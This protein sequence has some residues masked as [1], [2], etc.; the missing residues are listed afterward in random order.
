MKAVFIS[1]FVIIFVL[2]IGI[3]FSPAFNEVNRCIDQE[4]TFTLQSTEKLKEIQ[5]QRKRREGFCED[6]EASYKRLKGCFEN[7]TSKDFLGSTFVKLWPGYE[8]VFHVAIEGHNR[9]CPDKL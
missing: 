7:A 1:L 6:S 3:Y 8:K 4:R 9:I 5:S 2:I